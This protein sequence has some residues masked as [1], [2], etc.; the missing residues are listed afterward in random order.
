MCDRR[1]GHE[2]T[3]FC[4]SDHAGD[5]TNS[6]SVAAYVHMIAGGVI[7]AWCGQQDHVDAST[8]GAEYV[9]A[10]LAI[11]SLRAVM[12]LVDELTPSV[13]KRDY[14]P[15]LWCD[16]QVALDMLSSEHM[17]KGSKKIRVRY[18]LVRNE[19]DVLK[20]VRLAKV[21]TKLNP[22][23]GFTKPLSVRHHELF[24]ENLKLR[25]AKEVLE[26]AKMAGVRL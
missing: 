4:D 2:L 12:P 11:E 10:S 3:T 7:D 5:V 21:D 18:H 16:S 25:H 24:I 14:I 23:D 15:T 17:T 9:A 20:E 22:A 1:Y 19:A 26:L 8:G 6:R 13:E